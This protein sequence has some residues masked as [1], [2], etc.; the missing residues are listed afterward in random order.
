VSDSTIKRILQCS[1]G[2]TAALVAEAERLIA[3][4]TVI[5]TQTIP[6]KNAEIAGLESKLA[7][8]SPPAE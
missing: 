4:L 7:A 5:Q 3:L 1:D 2:E 6:A 8:L